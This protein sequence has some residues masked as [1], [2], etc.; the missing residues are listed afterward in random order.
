L[1]KNLIVRLVF[2]R[3][4]EGFVPRVPLIVQKAILSA[5]ALIA[6]VAGIE[7]RLTKYT[8]Q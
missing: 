2:I 7:E 4:S 8:L 3:M 1:P 6:R 5:A